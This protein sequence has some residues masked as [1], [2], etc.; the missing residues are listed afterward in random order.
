MRTATLWLCV[1]C[2]GCTGEIATPSA[3]TVSPTGGQAG[4]GSGSGSG[5]GGGEEAETPVTPTA[6]VTSL[7]RLS[8]AEL[9]A[10][11]SQLTGDASH[12]ALSVLPGDDPNPF[13]NEYARQVAS[14]VWLEAVEKV[15]VQVTTEALAD[16]K[17]RALLLPCTPASDDDLQCLSTFIKT[18][19]RK[20]LR[21]PVTAAEVTQLQS[22]HA[23]ARQR[24]TFITSAGLVAQ[25]LLLDGEFLFRVEQGTA[26][27]G[28][29][30]V[31]ALAPNELATRL[32]FVLQGRAPD[33]WL[34]DAAAAGDLS[35]P[36]GVRAAAVRLMAEPAGRAQIERFHAMWLGYQSLPF[37][38]DLA[39]AAYTET[40]ALVRKV[41]L[42]DRADYAQLFTAEQ[43]Y[44]DDA[45]A[46]HYG[47]PTTGSPGFH[48]ASYGAGSSR[49]GILSH[50]ALLANG[51]KASDT[52]PTRRGKWVRN[53][54]FCQEIA[55]PPPNVNAD[56]PPAGT[57][58]VVCKKDRYREHSTLAAC[59]SCHTQM[60]PIGFGLEQYDRTGAF[61]AVEA[62][63]PE[64]T[65]A[66]DGALA[67]VGAFNGPGGLGAL[68]VQ[69]SSFE[70]C[71]VKQVFRFTQGRRELGSDL[72]L[73]QHLGHAFKDSGRHFDE[74]LLALVTHP[75]FS[76]R[77]ETP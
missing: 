38:A 30:G 15:V 22:L 25:R 75:T 37:D 6:P 39:A 26:V 76:Q 7:R 51:V 50:A 55:D 36:E 10:T 14:A 3:K 53:R 46:A 35:T 64:C 34:L 74:V 40:T 21:R 16:T 31:F 44:V 4:S 24:G 52:S 1:V 43:T 56:V 48:W 62:E 58:G 42:D 61:R 32:A 54:L 66:G 11:L 47:M 59:A 60:D 28:Q 49:R 9:D 57:G 12:L 27:A 69:S 67:G 13:D 8:R 23:L 33:A 19:G 73:L 70:S 72:G 5:S 41:V 18:F 77:T 68:L 45:L 17:R 71:V 63:H 2:I 65:I 29:A 20:V